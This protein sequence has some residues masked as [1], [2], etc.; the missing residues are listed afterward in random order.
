MNLYLQISILIL[1]YLLGSIPFG[2]LLTRLAGYG[3][4]R[5]IGS[6]NIGATNVLRTG[7]RKLAILT[8]LLDGAK[9]AAAVL[10]VGVIYPDIAPM[11]GFLT[12][13]GHVYP[14]WLSFKGGKGVATAIGV[15]TALAWPVGLATMGTWIIVAYVSR[16]SSL[17]ALLALGLS[18]AYAIILGQKDWIWL[19][20]C[21][22][23]LI[24]W[25][26][27]PNIQRLIEGKEPKIGEHSTEPPSL[28]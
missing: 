19:T 17:A 11:A 12:L 22:L 28:D 10:I 3:D 6:G 7:D 13:V 20:V 8:L 4:I 25:K 18:P 27:A 1:C 26:H 9:G 5:K 21:M 23:L 24:A 16:F 2:Y 14:I 15:L